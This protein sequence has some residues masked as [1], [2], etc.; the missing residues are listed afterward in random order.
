MIKVI[1][2]L[3]NIGDLDYLEYLVD[4]AHISSRDIEVEEI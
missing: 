2:Y 4:T 3:D 1:V